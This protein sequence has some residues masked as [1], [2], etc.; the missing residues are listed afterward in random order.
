MGNGSPAGSLAASVLAP[1]AASTDGVEPCIRCGVAAH[2]QRTEGTR[3]AV[4]ARAVRGMTCGLEG[5]RGTIGSYRAARLPASAMELRGA[6]SIHS[7]SM[8]PALSCCASQRQVASDGENSVTI[9]GAMPDGGEDGV[10]V[11]ATVT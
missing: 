4:R 5:R 1:G 2:P 8:G 10:T 11:V 9:V 7:S 6:A 3:S